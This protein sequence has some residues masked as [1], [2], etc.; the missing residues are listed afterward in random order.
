MLCHVVHVSVALTV[1]AMCFDS[2]T[3][4]IATLPSC[5]LYLTKPA[6]SCDCTLKPLEVSIGTSSYL[7]SL[8]PISTGPSA[9]GAALTGAESCM[10]LVAAA[11]PPTAASVDIADAPY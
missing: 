8:P 10:S 4:G 2:F 1:D 11:V 3:C 7:P 9:A 5:S 6:P